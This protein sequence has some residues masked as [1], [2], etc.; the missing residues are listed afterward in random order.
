MGVSRSLIVVGAVALVIFW[1]VSTGLVGYAASVIQTYA[2]TSSRTAFTASTCTVT[3]LMMMNDVPCTPSVGYGSVCWLF[4]WEVTTVIPAVITAALPSNSNASS[5]GSSSILM[6]VQVWPSSD[7]TAANVSEIQAFT[8]TWRERH[9]NVPCWIQFNQQAL[10]FLLFD[11]PAAVPSSI[12]GVILVGIVGMM[13]V[14]IVGGAYAYSKYGRRS[15]YQ[16]F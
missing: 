5:S 9:Q 15:M 3:Q 16:T 12:I 4:H 10:P 6:Y 2:T 7:W 1:T 14:M 11:S 8:R 13:T